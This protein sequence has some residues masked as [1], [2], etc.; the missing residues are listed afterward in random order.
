M[1]R[2][3]SPFRDCPARGS[4]PRPSPRQ[5]ASGLLGVTLATR[6]KQAASIPRRLPM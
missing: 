2:G 3:G 5:R 1:G 4:Y 6:V